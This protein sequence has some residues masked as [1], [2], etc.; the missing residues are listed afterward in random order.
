M[1]KSGKA[2]FSNN[3]DIAVEVSVETL[4][5]A[6]DV[7]IG[8]QEL[9]DITSVGFSETRL[10]QV[11]IGSHFTHCFKTAVRQGFLRLGRGRRGKHTHQKEVLSSKTKFWF[12]KLM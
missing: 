1:G 10:E 8:R 9:R 5:K 2:S 3:D 4:D 12:S 7:V 6:L 11:D